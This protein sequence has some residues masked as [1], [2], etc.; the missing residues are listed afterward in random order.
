ME[1]LG[2]KPINP[3]VREREYLTWAMR[4][5]SAWEIGGILH[6]SEPAVRFYQGNARAKLDV[7]TT[8]EAVVKAYMLGLIRS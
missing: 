4:G 2:G 7:T 1:S 5:K 8:R 3:A 6:I